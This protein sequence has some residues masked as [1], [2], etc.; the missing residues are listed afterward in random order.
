MEQLSI[1]LYDLFTLCIIS[2]R[3]VAFFIT[4][5]PLSALYSLIYMMVILR[6]SKSVWSLVWTIRKQYLNITLLYHFYLL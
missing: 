1:K 2:S 4:K 3:D 5:T 6:E